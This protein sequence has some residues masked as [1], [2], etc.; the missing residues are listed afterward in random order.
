MP[1]NFMLLLVHALWAGLLIPWQVEAAAQVL[2]GVTLLRSSRGQTGTVP[3]A[4]LRG[5]WPSLLPALCPA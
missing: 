3:Q 4:Q 2:P 5:W 1:G